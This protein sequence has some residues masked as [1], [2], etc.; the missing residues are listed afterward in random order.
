MLTSDTP[1]TSISI[2]Q[3][4]SQ[5][6]FAKP[7]TGREKPHPST[8]TEGIQTELLCDE[9]EPSTLVDLVIIFWAS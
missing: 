8:T 6:L 5:I 7:Y 2:N 1:Q 4:S 3:R 9:R